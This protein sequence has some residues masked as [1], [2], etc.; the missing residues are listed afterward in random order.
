MAQTIALG[1]MVTGGGFVHAALVSKGN[2][3]HAAAGVGDN[4]LTVAFIA[5]VK[6]G[7]FRLAHTAAQSYEPR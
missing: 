7:L 1:L 5:F 4:G 3:V 2:V 6:A